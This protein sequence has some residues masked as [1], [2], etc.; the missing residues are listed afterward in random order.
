[1]C[2]CGCSINDIYYWLPA[3]DGDRYTITI[4]CP[5]EDCETPAGI[6][7]SLVKRDK[8]KAIEDMDAGYC[9]MLDLKNEAAFPI[10]YPHKL[11]YVFERLLCKMFRVN[12]YYS[13]PNDLWKMIDGIDIDE[14][15][16]NLFDFFSTTI[17]QGA[18]KVIKRNNTIVGDKN[19]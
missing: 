16:S 10:M 5:C 4:T 3:P 2:E 18:R 6:I 15:K 11:F 7:V 14:T 8:V 9:D 17:R 12:N 1:M 19:D 13:I